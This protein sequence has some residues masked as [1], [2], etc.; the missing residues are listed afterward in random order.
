MRRVALAV[1]ALVLAGC[2]ST[3]TAVDHLAGTQVGMMAERE[4]EEMHPGMARGSLTC[5]TLP[6][7]LGASVRCLRVAELSGGRVVRMYG[8]VAV[9]STH[10]G[11][12]LHVAMDDH[13]T[14]FGVSSERLQ[15]DLAAVVAKR[16]NTVP[17]AVRCP[18]LAGAPGT[19]VRCTVQLGKVS[20][21][22]AAIVTRTDPATYQTSY[23]FVLHLPLHLPRAGSRG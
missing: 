9:R 15:S 6:F 22:V 7:R 12:E 19:S 1:V 21:E 18:Y 13:V 17:T 23:R 8:T 11:G 20:T 2:G 4:L 10:D 5:P 14:E 3:A 16:T